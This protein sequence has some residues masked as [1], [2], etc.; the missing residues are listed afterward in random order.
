MIFS[1]YID[2]I[3]DM[4]IFNKMDSVSGMTRSN[5]FGEILIILWNLI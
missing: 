2:V 5:D 1:E 3:M 4:V